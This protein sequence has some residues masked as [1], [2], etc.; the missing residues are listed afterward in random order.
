MDKRNIN[1]SLNDPLLKAQSFEFA[2]QVTFSLTKKNK[3]R[4]SLPFHWIISPRVRR[5]P[6]SQHHPL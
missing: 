2:Q 1:D 5:K 3:V 4:V 6:L